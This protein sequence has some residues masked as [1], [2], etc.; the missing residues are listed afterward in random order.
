MLLT[1]TA[2]TQEIADQ[3]AKIFNPYLL[4]FPADIKKQIPSFAFPF[5]PVD[6]SRG[7]TYE[8]MLHHVV[9]LEDP[10]ELVKIEYI[11]K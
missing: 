2:K 1:V 6:F 8:F 3:I 5:S 7:R 4:H 10:L 11:D 9:E